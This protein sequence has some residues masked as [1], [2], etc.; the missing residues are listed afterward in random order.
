MTDFRTTGVHQINKW[1]W[2]RLNQWTYKNDGVGNGIRAF[3]AYAIDPFGNPEAGKVNLVPIIPSQQ[4]PEFTNL[5]DGPP[6][7]V[8]TYTTSPIDVFAYSEQAAYVIYDSNEERLRA[9]LHY[10]ISIFKGM[11]WTAQAVNDWFYSVNEVGTSGDFFD[12]KWI[13]VTTSVGPDQFTSE[14]GRQGAMVSIRYEF[15][16]DRDNDYQA[17]LTQG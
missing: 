7:I 2:D 4:V 13:T 12:F 14:G 8:Y 9:I 10:M 5:T 6:F 15:T 17:L 3:D 16:H 11:D 1:L